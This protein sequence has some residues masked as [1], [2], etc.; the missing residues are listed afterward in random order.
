MTP[1]SPFTDS[2]TTLRLSA[3]RQRLS[4]PTWMEPRLIAR[5][6]MA[7]RSLRGKISNNRATHEFKKC[8]RKF[9]LPP[10]KRRNPAPTFQYDRAISTYAGTKRAASVAGTAARRLT[11]LTH[12]HIRTRQRPRPRRSISATTFLRSQR[13]NWE[14]KEP[15]DR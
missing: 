10:P 8:S 5:S 6:K 13:H 1:Y 9:I 15:A 3:S 12:D 2:A 7:W 14:R 4:Y 11:G